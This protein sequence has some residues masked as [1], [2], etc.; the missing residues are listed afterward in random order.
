MRRPAK[1]LSWQSLEMLS[2]Q[3]RLAVP[4]EMPPPA[5]PDG[6]AKHPACWNLSEVLEGQVAL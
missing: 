2:H 3:L 4:E 6:S 5:E 1:S